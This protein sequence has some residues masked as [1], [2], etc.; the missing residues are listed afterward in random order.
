[1]RIEVTYEDGL[2]EMHRTEGESALS[3]DALVRVDQTIRRQ[4][5]LGTTL[6]VRLDLL[7]S[8]GL[9]VDVWWWGTDRDPG[10]S[11]GSRG[12][13]ELSF[14]PGRT[15]RIVSPELMAKVVAVDIDGVRRVE[16]QEGFLVDL[17]RFRDAQRF[18]LGSRQTDAVVDQVVALHERIR[19]AHPSW[20]DG[21]VC[22]EYGYQPEAYRAIAA[23]QRSSANKGRVDDVRRL[24]EGY[25]SEHPGAIAV[26]VMDALGISSEEIAE[27]WEDAV[28]GREADQ[29]ASE[30]ASSTDIGLLVDLDWGDDGRESR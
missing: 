23:A 5:A 9:R 15:W 20:D 13:P 19:Q 29:G 24:V 27:V 14:E 18:W 21:R 1:M 28:G 22:A 25:L 7:E 6:A 11:S 2:V 4:R 3:S 16:R 30:C 26:E 8:E 12:L 17:T 10:A